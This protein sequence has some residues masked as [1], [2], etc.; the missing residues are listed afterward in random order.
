M[1]HSKQ[2]PILKSLVCL[3][4]KHHVQLSYQIEHCKVYL[5]QRS[6]MAIINNTEKVFASFFFD[7]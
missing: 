5:S 7:K 6:N 2:L 4:L 1:E 3:T